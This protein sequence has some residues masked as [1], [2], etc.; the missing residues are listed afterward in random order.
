MVAE[1]QSKIMILILKFVYSTFAGQIKSGLRILKYY[2]IARETK[3]LS[4][5]KTSMKEMGLPVTASL[6]VL[7]PFLR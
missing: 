6:V 5:W 1:Y 4:L 2:N 3:K 7:P